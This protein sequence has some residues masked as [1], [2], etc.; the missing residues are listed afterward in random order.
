MATNLDWFKQTVDRIAVSD[1]R[2]ELLSELKVGLCGLSVR[3]VTTVANVL[4]LAVIFDTL[5]TNEKEQLELACDVLGK[6]LGALEPSVVLAQYGQ[7]IQHTLIHPSPRAKELVLRELDRAVTGRVDM[8]ERLSAEQDL[9]VCIVD[10]LCLEELSVARYAISLLKHLGSSPAGLTA[11]Y[12]PVTMQALQTASSKG[13]IV[14]FR[15]YEVVVAVSVESDEGLRASQNSGFLGGM[16]SELKGDDVLA[17]LNVLE[18]T[19]T[20]ALKQHSLV[21]LDQ[22]GI[23]DFL[24]EKL[25]NSENDPLS[26]F[27]VPGLI[28]FF[29]NVAQSKPD[30]MIKRFPS[31]VS[32][33]FD[34]LDASDLAV[35]GTGMETL[36]FIA[37]TLKGKYMLQ[38]LG[39]RLPETM[40]KMVEKLPSLPI[41]MKVRLLNTIANI[42]QLNV[43]D[44]NNQS[45]S[46]T[47][48]WFEALSPQPMDFVMALCRQPFPE[49][50]LAG[51]QLMHVLAT[52]PW[53][54]EYIVRA[55]GVVEYLMD[56]LTESVKSCKDAKFEVVRSLVASPSSST[57]MSPDVL[58]Q[59]RQFMEQGEFYARG[60]TEVAIEGAS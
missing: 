50:R 17:Q 49:T 44:Q 58:D 16:F 55:P 11:L 32:M 30:E 47:K 48:R 54:Q 26:S 12:S 36:G 2:R 52:N 9:L 35:V 42:L 39:T 6:L 15:V 60:E 40:R 56:R 7:Q 4:P 8:V 53:G 3:D 5:N 46:M 23:L 41:E 57:V 13:D 28:K 25:S 14:R 1:S 29:G 22:Q 10:C 38:S 20:L 37:T 19:T 45:L 21:F 24:A 33:M 18:M 43:S 27:L 51:F 34:T 59:L 31:L